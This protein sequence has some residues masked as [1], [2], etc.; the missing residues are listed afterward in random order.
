MVSTIT[1]I[2]AGR[3]G[4][5]IFGGARELSFLQ[6]IPPRSSYHPA[7]NSIKNTAFSVAV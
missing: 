4:V 5:Q 6:N 3:S 1:R 2:Y 7:S